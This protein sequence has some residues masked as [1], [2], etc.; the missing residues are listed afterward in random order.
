MQQT[1]KTRKIK[2]KKPCYIVYYYIINI[3]FDVTLIQKSIMK[4]KVLKK[5][6]YCIKD[7]KLSLEIS[8]VEV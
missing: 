2:I 3:M 6:E 4:E 1:I 7:V 5:A 8:I